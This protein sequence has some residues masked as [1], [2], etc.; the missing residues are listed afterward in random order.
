M[1]AEVKILHEEVKYT[2]N[3]DVYS[4]V[5]ALI[6]LGESSFVRRFIVFPKRGKR[7]GPK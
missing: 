7:K 3:G 4:V 2:V 1:Q 6:I 5:H